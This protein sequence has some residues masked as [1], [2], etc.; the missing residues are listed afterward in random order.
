MVEANY[1]AIDNH[2]SIHDS[3]RNK[4][5]KIGNRFLEEE[6]SISLFSEIHKI[7]QL[8]SHHFKGMDKGFV[9]SLT[10]EDVIYQ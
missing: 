3:L 6:I 2:K 4:L 5:E 7:I 10:E 8:I 9:V 1:L